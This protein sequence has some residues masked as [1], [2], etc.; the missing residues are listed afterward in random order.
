MPRPGG[1][2]A[3]EERGGMGRGGMGRGGMVGRTGAVLPSWWLPVRPA[4]C[5]KRVLFW[6]CGEEQLRGARLCG[7]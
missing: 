2:G 6:G 1:R 5:G 7:R 3:P 4:H